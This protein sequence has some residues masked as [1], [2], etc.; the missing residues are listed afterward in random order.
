MGQSLRKIPRWYWKGKDDDFQLA[1]A[2]NE[3]YVRFDACDFENIRSEQKNNLTVNGSIPF[4]EQDVING[5][6]HSKA[7]K[8]AG[9]DN[10]EGR[11]LI[12]CAEQLGPIFYYI[13]QL[14][15]TQQKVP[16]LWKTSPVI[17]V[18]KNNHPVVL[19]DFRPVALTSLVVKS[20][21]R[22]LKEILTKV[23][24][25]LDPLQFAYRARR[26]VEDAT[27]TLLNWYLS[28]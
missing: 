22:L 26:G 3:F 25:S 1:K 5:F 19:N 6:K 10:I 12:S 13:F 21:E 8:S 14:S 24:D 11:L 9:P 7:R 17:P 18:V 4:A 2:F 20:F 16:R 23:E 15:L 28:I 27:A